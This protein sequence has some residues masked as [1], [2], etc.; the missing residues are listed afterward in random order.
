VGCRVASEKHSGFL[1]VYTGI[2]PLGP[3]VESS[4]K[5][6]VDVQLTVHAVALLVVIFPAAH[7]FFLKNN[8]NSTWQME[9][10]DV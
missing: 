5:G 7:F 10:Q 9:M 1:G 8:Q 3:G 2:N 4:P 6:I